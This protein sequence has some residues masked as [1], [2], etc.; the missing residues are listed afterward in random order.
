M[1]VKFLLLGSPKAHAGA[2]KSAVGKVISRVLGDQ[3]PALC[4]PKA[5]NLLL[6]SF[7]F[8]LRAGKIGADPTV[9]THF[10]DRQTL[11]DNFCSLL[12]RGGSLSACPGVR[13]ARESVKD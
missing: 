1:T 2:V 8:L 6:E 13:S 5:R 4:G 9:V 11:Q 3:I 12:V 7:H 10:C